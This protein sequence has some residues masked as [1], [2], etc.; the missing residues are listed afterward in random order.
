MLHQIRAHKWYKSAL[1]YY[2][3]VTTICVTIQ[4]SNMKFQEA[5]PNW[6][7]YL[8]EHKEPPNNKR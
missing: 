2:E 4:K 1:H 5:K 6:D 8:W 7:Q 3:V